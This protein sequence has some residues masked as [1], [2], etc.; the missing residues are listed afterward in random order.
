MFREIPEY[1]RFVNIL[2]CTNCENGCFISSLSTVTLRV[3]MSLGLTLIVSHLGV[4]S[5]V[6]R[7]DSPKVRLSKGHL[8]RTG[9]RVS[10]GLVVGLSDFWTFGLSTQ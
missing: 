6:Q 10:I 8:A 9:V 3:I 5:I 4:C 7:F 2:T 1:C